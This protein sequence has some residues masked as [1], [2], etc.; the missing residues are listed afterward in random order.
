M[1]AHLIE[2]ARRLDNLIRLGTIHSVDLP[3]ARAR[4]TIGGLTTAWLPW[5]AER[6]GTTRQWSAPT[7]GEQVMVLSPGG[8]FAAGVILMS[9][10]STASAAPSNSDTEHLTVY[11]DGARIAYDHAT[12][13]LTATGVQTATLQSAGLVTIDAPDTHITGTLT[14]DQLLTYGNGLSG[15]G[16]SNGNQISGDFTHAS[17]QLSSNGIVLDSHQHTGVQPG[18]STTGGPV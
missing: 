12:G 9:A 1:D 6:A 14:V 7:V 16:G 13:A 17:G 11:P 3:N 4:V 10:Y 15:T 8:D 5:M 2:L 18:G